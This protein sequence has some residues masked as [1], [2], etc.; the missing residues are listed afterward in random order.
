MMWFI[1]Y[2]ARGGVN[3]PALSEPTTQMFRRQNRERFCTIKR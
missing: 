2:D 3:P 1:W